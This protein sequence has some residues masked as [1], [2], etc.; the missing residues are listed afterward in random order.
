[1]AML[2]PWEQIAGTK[3]TGRHLDRSAVVYI[4]QS[5]RQQVLDHQESTRL[6]YA[7]VDRAAA[8]GW[9]RDRVQVI[10]EDL[11]KSGSSAVARTGFQRLV[12]EI[13]LDHVGLVLGIEMSRLARSGRDWYQLMELCAISGTLLGDSDGV[14]DPGD[15]NDRL[16]L[17]LKGTMAEAELHLLK[18]RMQ[19]G[20]LNKARRGELALP[21]PTGYVRRPS[22]EVVLDP[23]EQV[24]AVVGLIFDKFTELK[25]THGVLRYLVDHGIEI[26]IRL[27]EGPDKGEL[28]WRRP[29]RMTLQNVLHSPVYAGIYAYGRRRVDPRRQQPG[30]PATGRVSRSENEWLVLVPGVLPAYISLERYHANLAQMKANASRSGASGTPRAGTA[31]LSGV[32]RC[33]M[34]GKRM[35]VLYHVRDT[36]R[37]PE[38]RCARLVTDY[39]AAG[40]CQSLSGS[41]LDA[42]VSAAV[43]AAVAPAALQASLQAAGQIREERRRL[44]QIWSARLERAA[45][46]VDRARRCY[47]LAE[48]ENRL[49]VRQLEKDWEASLT[50]QQ[51]LSEEHDRFTATT[52]QTLSPAE[53]TAIMALA[54]D[55][56]G[57]WTAPTT[58]DAD[59]KEII[60]TVLTDVSVTVIGDSERVAV[61]LTWAG[62]HTTSGE[63]ARPVARLTQLSYYPELMQR[64]QTLHQQGRNAA[65]IAAALDAEGFR[66]PKRIPHFTKDA[67]QRLLPRVYITPCSP[68]RPG[69]GIGGPDQPGRHEWWLPDLAR[70]LDMPQA[71]LYTWIQRGWVTARQDTT[72]AHRWIIQANPKTLT[73]LRQRRTR[74]AG[75]YTRHR[76]IDPETP[77]IPPETDAHAAVARLRVQC[78]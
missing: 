36:V 42:Y 34:C 13:G 9:A 8:L 65:Q 63:L 21:L 50:E 26:G 23:D 32:L 20:R 28:E 22:G 14:Y 66:P 19:S 53:E 52:P 37:L 75:Y 59:R 12:S 67:V 70:T 68:P 10:D 17:G 74:P 6:Q 62:G 16:L 40:P 25:T 41:C 55:V 5:S 11:G 15:Y 71:T 39:G 43:L 72:T 44:E 38:Y 1:M 30:R 29:N 64:V 3:V 54:S 61:T 2:A 7:L 48:P 47:R 27:H 18:Q 46:N 24:R 56:P 57:L 69:T 76:W 35:T 58:T 33:G 73:E 4:R 51:H 77:T 49:V 78:G 45:Y 31:L 60:R